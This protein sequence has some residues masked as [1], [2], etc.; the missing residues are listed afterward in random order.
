MPEEI[1]AKAETPAPKEV[2]AKEVP[3]TPATPSPEEKA[4]EFAH[5]IEKEEPKTRFPKKEQTPQDKEEGF[6][7]R[8]W[9]KEM[10]KKVD[11]GE[12]ISDDDLTDEDDKP[13]TRKEFNQMLEQNNAKQ[14]SETML[15]EFLVEKPEYRKFAPLL[16]KHL[17]D[18][19]YHNIPIGFIAN[20]IRGEYGIDDEINARAE[21][22]KK[23]DDEAL[24]SK[25]GGS[26]KRTVPGKKKNVW[27]MSKDE[28]E[29]HQADILQSK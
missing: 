24:N 18:P 10:K 8:Q 26:S 23:A 1:P 22:K 2:P 13:I 11:A 25:S 27:D 3:E 15:Q 19:A 21:M 20:G 5:K 29:A 14:S 4:K 6:K 16:R 28:F 9:K 12:T 17:N 7:F